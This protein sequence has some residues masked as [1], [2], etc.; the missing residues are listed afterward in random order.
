[1]GR[2]LSASEQIWRQ[3]PSAFAFLVD[4]HGFVGPERTDEGIAFHRPGLHIRIGFWSWKNERGFDTQVSA[5]VGAEKREL[6]A[7]LADLYVAC[8]LGPAQAVPESG[9]RSTHVIEKR[10]HE[11][12]IALRALLPY[13]DGSEAHDLLH[14]CQDRPRRESD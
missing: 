7:S 12:A 3:G 10:L 1:M 4:E 5:V 13:L 14:R 6:V 2:R 9:T 8:G 11:H